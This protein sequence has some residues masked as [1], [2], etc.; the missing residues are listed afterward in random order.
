MTSQRP[1]PRF[2]RLPKS[3]G[4]FCTGESNC[5]MRAS[6]HGDWPVH[7]RD[8]SAG[9]SR[10]RTVRRVRG[11]SLPSRTRRFQN[12]IPHWPNTL[13]SEERNRVVPPTEFRILT[14]TT[15]KRLNARATPYSEHITDAREKTYL[16]WMGVRVDFRDGR[17]SACGWWD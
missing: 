10:S 17:E 12:P 14:Q 13:A 16:R 4:V 7:Q 11:A 8:G 2:V 9:A 3:L 1:I 15:K 5:G 6:R